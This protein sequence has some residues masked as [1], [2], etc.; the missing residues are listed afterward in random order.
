MQDEAIHVVSMVVMTQPAYMDEIK[1][2]LTAIPGSE[3]HAISAEGKLVVTLEADNHQALISRI[4][5]VQHLDHVISASL[6]YH[7]IA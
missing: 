7:Q 3:V 2:S 6:V 1:T 5:H 4:D